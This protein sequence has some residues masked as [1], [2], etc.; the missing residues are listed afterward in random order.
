MI[1]NGLYLLTTDTIVYGRT[2]NK[3]LEYAWTQKP[4][5]TNSIPAGTLCYML[6]IEI[7]REP[8]GDRL[9]IVVIPKDDPNYMYELN[10]F[11]MTFDEV[12]IQ[13]EMTELL[14]DKA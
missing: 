10:Y 8:Q 11:D 14:Y 6:T 7:Y 1:T 9:R 3:E 13:N 4:L 12:F 5:F 2:S